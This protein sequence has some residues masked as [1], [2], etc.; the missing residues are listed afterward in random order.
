M[1]E[2]SERQAADNNEWAMA[3]KK[4]EK[5]RRRKKERENPMIG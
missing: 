4:G 3:E 1:K 2:K 5:F